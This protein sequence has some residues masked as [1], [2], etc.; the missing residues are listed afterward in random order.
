MD[1]PQ[2]E[3]MPEPSE[4]QSGRQKNNVASFLLVGLIGLLMGAVLLIML[5]DRVPNK[6]SMQA[7]LVPTSEKGDGSPPEKL[8]VSQSEVK[9]YNG[10]ETAEL[11]LTYDGKDVTQEAFWYSDDP[12]VAHVAT[13][14]PIKGQVNARGIG[15][16]TVRAVYNDEFTE[17]KF[18]VIQPGLA[19]DCSLI[20][21]EAKVGEEVELV[22]QYTEIGIPF[23]EYRWSG[24]GGLESVEAT[25]YIT[26]D[27]PG[28]KK[29][30]YE[31]ADTEGSVTK[32]D[33][34]IRVVE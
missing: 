30:H 15:V 2:R 20:P 14:E 6:D 32:M 18:V 8:V 10:G 29:I 11:T 31:T 28:I 5:A 26:Y 3:M 34:E 22:A 9:V 13:K 12:E 16:T 27:S 7:D 24:D 21:K 1:N 23:Y 4:S 17:T 19:T 33:C 25:A